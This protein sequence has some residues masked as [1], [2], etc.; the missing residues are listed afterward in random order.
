MTAA[1]AI[2]TPLPAHPL[3]AVDRTHAFRRTSRAGH[4]GCGAAAGGWLSQHFGAAAVF[5]FCAILGAIW[6][7]LAV[8]MRVPTSLDTR[9][10]Q[11]P[12]MDSQAVSGLTRKLAGIPGV[13]E[14]MLSGDGVAYL[15]VDSKGFD[16]QN[17]IKLLAGEV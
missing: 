4:H 17:V 12:K 2:P 16:E 15:R 1:T 9:R 7:L 6:L 3:P 11:L 13:R 5:G 10:F 14:V 8:G